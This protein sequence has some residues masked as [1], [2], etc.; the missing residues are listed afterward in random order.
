MTLFN[1]RRNAVHESPPATRPNEKTWKFPELIRQPMRRVAEDSARCSLT[2]CLFVNPLTPNEKLL[3]T[4]IQSP[5]S[6]L[7]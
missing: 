7:T 3:H 4:P 5:Q 2:C 1:R 6:K